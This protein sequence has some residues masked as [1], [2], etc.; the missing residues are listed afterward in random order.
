MQSP[1]YFRLES[2]NALWPLV[3]AFLSGGSIAWARLW[4]NR[5]KPSS[6]IQETNARTRKTL[7]ETRQLDVDSTR[8]VAEVVVSMSAKLA[9][10]QMEIEAQRVRHFK[11]TD[12]LKEQLDHR[13]DQEE[14]ARRRAHNAIDEVNRAVKYIKT[15]EAFLQN[16]D[17]PFEPFVV[18]T[19]KEIMGDDFQ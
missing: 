19:Y 8:T 2:W 11:E 7:A 12:Y 16:A 13:Q 14:E 5:K 6:D 10:V 4:L 1:D 9:E 17:I 3:L 15:Y 18:K